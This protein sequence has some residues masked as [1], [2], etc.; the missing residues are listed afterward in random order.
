MFWFRWT[1]DRL[2]VLIQRLLR[3]LSPTTALSHM[4]PV[5]C[6]VVYLS[7]SRLLIL[8]FSMIVQLECRC[9]KPV[10]VG[11]ELCLSYIPIDQPSK[12]R[13]AQLR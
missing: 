9:T 3:A 5:V 6:L 10:A 8:P 2:A 12:L 11:E 13:R 1:P 4:L 7:L